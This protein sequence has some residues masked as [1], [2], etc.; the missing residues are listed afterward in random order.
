MSLI[1]DTD[2]LIHSLR[3]SYLREVDDPYKSRIISLAPSYA[4]NPY[5]VSSGLA[6][7]SNWPELAMPSSPQLSDEDGEEPAAL[8]GARLKHTRTIMGGRTGGLGLRVTG[9]R[10]STSKRMSGVSRSADQVANFVS[11][12]GTGGIRGSSSL[13][14]GG[15]DKGWVKASDIVPEAEQLVEPAI[16]E[17]PPVP[18]VVQYIPKFK[19]ASEMA[20]RRQVRMAARRGPGAPV[21]GPPPVLES[22]SSS[23]DEIPIIV[24]S[25][26]DTDSDFGVGAIDSS[27]E[28]LD[29]DGFDPEQTH[30]LSS[31]PSDLVSELSGAHRD[32]GSRHPNDDAPQVSMDAAIA[33]FFDI[34][35]HLPTNNKRAKYYPPRRISGPV[36]PRSHTSARPPPLPVIPSSPLPNMFARK[37]VQ[38]LRH[39]Q[40][41]LTKLMLA[42]SGSLN[43]FAEIYAAVS[44]RAESQSTDIMVYVPHAT[45][46]RGKPLQ[47]NIRTEATIEEV[48]GFTLFKYWEEGW[49]PRLDEGWV[50]MIAEDDGEVDDDFPPPDRLQKAVKVNADAYALLE[51]TP[52][53]ITQNQLVASKIQRAP[54][55]TVN[56]KRPEK[57]AP[58]PTTLAVAP[59]V[60]SSSAEFGSALG[61]VPLSTSLGPT[62][63]HGPHILLKIRIAEAADSVL[64]TTIPVTAGMYLQEVLEIVCRKRNLGDPKDY[65]LLL[66]EISILIP[67]D[68]TVASL[69][70]KRELVLFKRSMLPQYGV[71]NTGRTT[72]P[73]ASIFKE[74]P[75]EKTSSPLDYTAAYKKYT[76]YRKMPMRVA[77]KERT[78][79]IDGVYIHVC[80]V[81]FTSI[82]QAEIVQVMPG[83][84]SK[85]PYNKTSSYHV[86]AIEEC[87]KA[88]KGSA[89]IKFVLLNRDRVAKRYD[90]EAESPALA[91]EIVQ[92][93]KSLKAALER[94]GTLKQ[95]HSRPATYIS[96]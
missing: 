93:I 69:Q 36:A 87:Q 49:L 92:T 61:S 50:L 14:E 9:K 24:E 60:P 6:D 46:P 55:R 75:E 43:P 80:S 1:S 44:G 95:R 18:R 59:V 64:Y 41:S 38:P 53:Q 31:S 89:T 77:R 33:P 65:A 34:V 7:P 19:G 71:K 88:S 90:I 4:S 32:N 15:D 28:S 3:L 37:P 94:S 57:A 22:D 2:F 40:S 82:S 12:Q 76:I 27:D 96:A 13:L 51:A 39:Q 48:V 29:G 45:K 86:K 58:V 16:E 47:L 63:G 78:L 20:A 67:L 54:S 10:A 17:E 72:D 42:S 91:T 23:D 73:N 70:G 30:G 52:S 74:T 85:K 8:Q 84:G 11:S 25:S 62:S 66:A 83:P 35:S 21:A 79:A 56:P 81:N 26:S 68:R 5:I